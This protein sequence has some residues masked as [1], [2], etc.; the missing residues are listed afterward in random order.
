MKKELSFVIPLMNR[1]Q[2]LCDYEPIPLK[3]FER[4]D[5]QKT[6]FKN[7]LK[8]VR[9]HIRLNLLIN[10][11]ESLEKIRGE[12]KFQIVLVDFGSTDYNLD[13]LVK[14]FSGLEILIIRVNEYFSRGRGLN[15]GYEQAKYANV[16]FC[17]ADMLFT[18]RDVIENGYSVIS[19]GKIY[20]PICMD[21]CDPTHQFGYWRTSG[22]GMC[23]VGKDMYFQS[24]YRWSEYGCLG[25]E[26]NDIWNIFNGKGMT[27]REKVDGYF[28]QWH[29]PGF[30]FK[31]QYYQHPDMNKIKIYC[32][33]DN[34]YEIKGSDLIKKVIPE[35][36][37]YVCDKLEFKVT[38]CVIDDIGK[39]A[40]VENYRRKFNKDLKIFYLIWSPEE[41]ETQL[42]DLSQTIHSYKELFGNMKIIRDLVTLQHSL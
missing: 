13:K 33:L 1:T 14:R 18:K 41:Y 36:V 20:F 5:L 2:V 25:K 29:P 3:L 21:L 23:I 35:R 10:C 4:H 34:R 31:N 11:L 27:V 37:G 8:K 42:K 28:H 32:N 6:G 40:E 30:A 15:I 19:K 7:E 26:D 12:D 22:Y 24:K 16:F 9:G 39:L 38:H 17:D